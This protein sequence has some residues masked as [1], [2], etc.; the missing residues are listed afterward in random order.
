MIKLFGS[1]SDR[2]AKTTRYPLVH[3]NLKVPDIDFTQLEDNNVCG[4]ITQ[5]IL[6]EV[7]D[8][9]NTEIVN[10]IH[11]TAVNEG[12]TDLFLI[13]KEFIM[14]AIHHE[15]ARRKATGSITEGQSCGNCSHHDD[16]IC[17]VCEENDTVVCMRQSRHV[18]RGGVCQYWVK[19][20]EEK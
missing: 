9:A 15:M 17:V 20:E 5:R 11:R 1:E 6:A 8:L 10:A 2:L 4:T 13:D 18:P 3:F 14:S 7:T 12:V 16:C 19:T